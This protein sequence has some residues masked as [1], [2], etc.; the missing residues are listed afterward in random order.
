MRRSRIVAV[1]HLNCSCSNKVNSDLGDS[2]GCFNG[3]CSDHRNNSAGR[4][5]SGPSF[6]LIVSSA[7]ASSRRAAIAA[8]FGMAIGS[9]LL[10]TAALLGLHV[11]LTSVPTIYFALKLGG[12]AYL[13]Y[14]AVMLWRGADSPVR[15]EGAVYEARGSWQG[16]AA[17]GLAIQLSN[18]KT[19]IV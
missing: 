18:P 2:H 16:S 14:L 8:A 1:L 15:I 6:V 11:V 3:A 19:A 9:I 7:V 13:L 17:R 5:E 4:H 12:A 10:A